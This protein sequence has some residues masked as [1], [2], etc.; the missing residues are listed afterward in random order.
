MS[1]MLL[2]K[3]SENDFIFFTCILPD[4]VPHESSK[5]FLKN[6]HFKNTRAG[7]LLSCQ[8]TLWQTTHEMMHFQA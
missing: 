4:Y 7:F 5:E 1:K 6:S 3:S 8:N 2:M